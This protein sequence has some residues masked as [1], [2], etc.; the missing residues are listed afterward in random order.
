M[1]YLLRVRPGTNVELKDVDP[2]F[3]DRHEGYQDAAKAIEDYQKRLRELLGSMP[4]ARP[5]HASA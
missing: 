5:E 3:K 2:A 1:K 4:C